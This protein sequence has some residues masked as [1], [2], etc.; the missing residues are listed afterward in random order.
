M[1]A[2]TGRQARTF[3]HFASSLWPVPGF[4][5]TG[6]AGRGPIVRAWDQDIEIGCMSVR[7][8]RQIRPKEGNLRVRP[9]WEIME[10]T[11]RVLDSGGPTGVSSLQLPLEVFQ[12]VLHMR[13]SRHLWGPTRLPLSLRL[14]DSWLPACFH[15]LCC[16]CTKGPWI[17]S[18]SE[19]ESELDSVSSSL[20]SSWQ[21]PMKA[22]MFLTISRTAEY[23]ARFSHEPN[24]PSQPKIR[25][26]SSTL[27]HLHKNA[28]NSVGKFC[29][30]WEPR[31]S[32]CLSSQS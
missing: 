12:V 25:I 15:A 18:Y 23:E 14:K 29:L 19:S 31:D 32:V 26:L 1:L 24:L 21:G 28:T 3:T 27:L 7:L 20:W 16:D 13:A 5:A 2:H 17:C 11:T 22:R 6:F 9:S 8:P 4:Q 10:N 30:H